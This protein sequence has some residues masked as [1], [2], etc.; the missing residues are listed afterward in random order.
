MHREKWGKLSG[1]IKLKVLGSLFKQQ[2]SHVVHFKTALQPC[3]VDGTSPNLEQIHPK[4]YRGHADNRI[5][6]QL[7]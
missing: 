7:Q 6:N 3:V 2:I 4:G 5:Q 1:K